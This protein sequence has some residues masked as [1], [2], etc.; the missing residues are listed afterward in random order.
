MKVWEKRFQSREHIPLLEKFNASILDDC[1]LYKTEITAS[2]AY[3]KGLAK[4]GVL[5]KDEYN[6]IE[7]GLDT[8]QRRIEAGESLES[9][10]D[11]HSAVELMLIE[12]VG[13]VGKKLHTG[14][15]RNEQVAT[16]E[17]LWL[18]ERTEALLDL[19]TEIQQTVIEKAEEHPDL[20]MPG[21]THLQ[22]GQPVLFSHYIMTLFW[23]MERAKQRLKDALK[24]T[25]CLSLGVGALAGS[26]IAIDRELLKNELGFAHC[27]ENSL[28]T[29]SDKSFILETLFALAL[30]FQD[31]AR[32]SEDFIIFASQ[33]FGYIDL[34][35]TIATSSSL[36]PQKRNPDYFELLRAVPGVIFGYVTQLFL[37]IKGLPSTYNKDLQNDKEPLQKGI[38]KSIEALGVFNIALA[39]IYPNKERIA[40]ALNSFLLATDLVDYLVEKGVSFREA[41]GI[42]GAIV[43][44]AEKSSKPL[45][46]YTAE[47]LQ[48]FSNLFTED[49]S[50]VFDFKHSLEKKKSQ[51]STNPQEVLKQIARAKEL[52]SK[53]SKK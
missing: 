38:E 33:E 9:F 42:I 51:G 6:S 15:S 4:A 13:E 30:T 25:N 32:A 40:A 18:K 52:L 46:A 31:V 7:S 26:T 53:D 10:E 12:E 36:M 48:I 47:E 16:D 17:R 44:N 39:K 35:D 37:V 3:A 27:S 29:V 41:H 24:R 22:Q 49:V 50:K 28:D 11:I 45:H 20:I 2:L 1:F 19:L 34:D 23:Q 43:D 5:T 8:V 14:R 21:Y